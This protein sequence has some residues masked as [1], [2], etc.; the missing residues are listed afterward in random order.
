MKKL[1]HGA[2]TSAVE[3]LVVVLIGLLHFNKNWHKISSSNR[4]KALEKQHVD[5]AQ[6]DDSEQ[7][8]AFF[9]IIMWVGGKNQ[10]ICPHDLD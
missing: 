5:I 3:L 2:C 9:L 6:A 7:Y 8:L 10:P 1:K 4:T